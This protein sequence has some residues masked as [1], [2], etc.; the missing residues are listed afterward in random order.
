MSPETALYLNKWKRNRESSRMSLEL[1]LCLG[2]PDFRLYAN[3]RGKAEPTS[4]SEQTYP[5]LRY[6][7]QVSR[8]DVLLPGILTQGGEPSLAAFLAKRRTAT[9]P[10][11]P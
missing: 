1:A 11:F 3:F 9:G 8:Q 7:K 6:A 2:A 10:A 5:R 4:A